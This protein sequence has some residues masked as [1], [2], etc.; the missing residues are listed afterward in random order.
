MLVI[1]NSSC[2]SG[3]QGETESILPEFWDAVGDIAIL[4]LRWVSENLKTKVN[5]L[6]LMISR[7]VNEL[8]H[9]VEAGKSMDVLG[10]ILR[11]MFML[12]IM[13]IAIVVI[14]RI[15]GKYGLARW[16]THSF[17][18][19]SSLI[20]HAIFDAIRALWTICINNWRLL[21]M[22]GEN[23]WIYWLDG[24]FF[25]IPIVVHERLLRINFMLLS[26]GSRSSSRVGLWQLCCIQ[27]QT[28]LHPD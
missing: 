10:D 26:R 14:I 7:L 13:V 16:A 27:P 2:L 25:F 11:S 9:V 24:C 23:V 19:C 8:F 6:L 3:C 17:V 28:L 22:V 4:I 15:Q 20:M 12:S 1:F 5:A 18:D 21:E